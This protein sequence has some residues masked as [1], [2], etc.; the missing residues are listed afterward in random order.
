MSSV[1]ASDAVGEVS[2]GGLQNLGGFQCSSREI[3]SWL[4]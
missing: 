3:V 1:V 2:S 4:L